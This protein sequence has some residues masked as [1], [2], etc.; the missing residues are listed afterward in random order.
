M[1]GVE[2]FQVLT[3]QTFQR[4]LGYEEDG[5]LSG[6]EGRQTDQYISHQFHESLQFK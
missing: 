5:N 1:S 3:F 6:A 4:R 2:I